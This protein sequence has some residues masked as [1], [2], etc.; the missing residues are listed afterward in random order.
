M[1]YL[2]NNPGNAEPSPPHVL[3]LKI[4]MWTL[5]GLGVIG[6]LVVVMLN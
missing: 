6:V 2:Q 3:V 1:E 4:A 5:L